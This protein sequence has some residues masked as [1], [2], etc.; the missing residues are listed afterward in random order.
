MLG[1]RMEYKN[2]RKLQIGVMGP[3]EKEYPENSEQRERINEAA[4]RRGRLIAKRNSILLTGG[5]GGVMLYASRG[6]KEE[7]GITVGSPG[8]TRNASNRYVDVEIITDIDAGSFIFAGLLG[9]DAIIFIPG[10]A[11]TL[12]E[13]C[14]AYR[15]KKRCIIMRGYDDFY[16]RLID[17][18]LDRGK[19]VKLL[20]AD[21]PEEAVNLALK[22]KNWPNSRK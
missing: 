4:E 22:D 15:N 16:D 18:Y 10:G 2:E 17:G 5:C 13:L 19:T 21:N 6:A 12:A 1:E 8:R 9:C 14:F 11:G 3:D 7:G 20:G